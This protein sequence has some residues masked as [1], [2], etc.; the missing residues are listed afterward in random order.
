MEFL[1]LL[2]GN[3]GEVLG[4]LLSGYFD[5]GW[6]FAA[7]HAVVLFFVVYKTWFRK[8]RTETKALESWKSDRSS[9]RKGETTPVLD[10]FVEDSEALGPQGILVPMTDYSDRLDSSVDGMVSELHDRINLLLLVGI[11]GSLFG[12][13]EFAF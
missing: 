8:I 4:R 7:L 13:Y 1:K 12:L 9:I 6:P 10:R 3:F 2:L 11:A 5:A